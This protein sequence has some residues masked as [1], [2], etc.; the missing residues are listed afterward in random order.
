MHPKLFTLSLPKFLSNLTGANYITIY[1]YAFCI[2]LSTVVAC[3]F[4]KKMA[5]KHLNNLVLP[6][7]FFYKIFLAG[8]V[9]GKLF[10]YLEKP[11]YYIQHPQ[12]LLNNFSGG[13]VC[14]GSILFIAAFTILYTRKYKIST[15]GL[16]DILAIAS[17]LPM[18][19]GR[20]G[21]YFGGCCYGKPT[22]SFLGVVFPSNATEHVH[23]TQLYDAFFLSIILVCLLLMNKYK[24]QQG[25]VFLLYI[26]LYAVQRFFLEF[27]R[28][29]FRGTLF[30]GFISHAQ[31]IA[32]FTLSIALYL[33][34][35][36]KK[37]YKSIN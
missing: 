30:N 12:L 2:V 8:F 7:S 14:Y 27:L 3:W 26:A 24:K 29:D 19:L 6:N 31:T 9:G 34:H 21:C 16:F 32:V 36:L 18:A 1:T 15:Y 20:V 37:Q 10:Y 11:V 33:F 5:S 13:F 4:I 28:G 23:P 17:I 35:Q 25:Q 22:N